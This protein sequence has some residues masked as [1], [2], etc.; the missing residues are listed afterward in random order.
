MC[1]QTFRN[2]TPVG[3]ARIHPSFT[4]NVDR[5]TSFQ[6]G[7]D[8]GAV[9]FIPFDQDMCRLAK[10]H[11]CSCE[12]TSAC[13]FIRHESLGNTLGDIMKSVLVNGEELIFLQCPHLAEPRHAYYKPTEATDALTGIELHFVNE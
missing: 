6:G 5:P 10:S 1:T 11:S 4:D 8:F 3:Q 2:E 7:N 9:G 12:G 13:Y